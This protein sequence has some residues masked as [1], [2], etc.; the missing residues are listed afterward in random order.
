MQQY[1]DVAIDVT[2]ANDTDFKSCAF[3]PGHMKRLVNGLIESESVV[4]G[5]YVEVYL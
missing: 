4:P 1:E 3:M 5:E 2:M